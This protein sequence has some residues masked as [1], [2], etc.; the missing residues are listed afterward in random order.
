MAFRVKHSRI[1][2]APARSEA[3]P[4]GEQDGKTA[5]P[6]TEGNM[7]PLDSIT[8]TIVSGVILALILAALF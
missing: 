5:R 7:N 3:G 1:G 8:G 4:R 2:P 6:A